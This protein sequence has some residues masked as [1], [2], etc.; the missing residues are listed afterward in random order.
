MEKRALTWINLHDVGV[1]TGANDKQLSLRPCVVL[2]LDELVPH[3][4]AHKCC[5]MRNFGLFKDTRPVCAN[6]L[7]TQGQCVSD[8]SRGLARRKYD[9]F[10][11]RQPLMRQGW[12]IRLQYLRK[13]VRRSQA[14]INAPR[15]DFSER[16]HQ[17]GTRTRFATKPE[18]PALNTGMA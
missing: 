15:C 1:E 5:L 4:V 18:A 17:I 14:E 11:V 9:K 13:D 2:L 16:V 7:C 6:G 3:S 10:A 8:E 12:P